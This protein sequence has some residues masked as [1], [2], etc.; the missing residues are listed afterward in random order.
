MS[1]LHLLFRPGLL[2]RR[3]E[4]RVTLLWHRRVLLHGLRRGL[5]FGRCPLC[6]RRAIFYKTGHYLRES[7]RCSWCFSAPRSRALMCV[8][9]EQFPGWRER[10]VHESSPGTPLSVTVARRGL[11][12][13][14]AHY[15]LDAP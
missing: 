2:Y 6:E 15:C 9:H 10:R 13:P 11:A 5:V 14:P 1:R 4:E 12:S 3:I 8:L 7:L